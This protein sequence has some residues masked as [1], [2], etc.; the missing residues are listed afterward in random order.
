MNEEKIATLILAAGRSSRAGHFKPLLPLGGRTV[1]ETILHS[2]SAA[3]I[4]DI[5][6]VLGHRAEDIKPVLDAHGVQWIVNAQY[7]LGMFSSIQTGVERLPPEYAAF[8]LQPADIPLVRPETILSLLSARRENR[9][10]IYY[11]CHHGRRGHPPL[12]CSSLFPAIETFDE[13]GGM[14]ALLSRYRNDAINVNVD[15]PGIHIDIDTPEDYE[16]ILRHA[17]GETL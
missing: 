14:R 2:Y 1:I 13:P 15:D 12:I 9:A 16:R 5:L 6:V 10:S 8:F 4:S 3:G 11:P 17:L 7:E